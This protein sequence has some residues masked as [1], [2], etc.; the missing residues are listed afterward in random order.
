MRLFRNI[1]NITGIPRDM[2]E[3]FYKEAREWVIMSNGK[4]NYLQLATD[5]LPRFTVSCPYNIATR[6][7]QALTQLDI[8]HIV[9]PNTNY[10][11]R[12]KLER[13]HSNLY[14]LELSYH[15]QKGLIYE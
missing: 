15:P 10:K 2:V 4:L 5:I 11:T 14:V 3:Q 6:R 8:D 9:D 12:D 1:S 7:D 13:W